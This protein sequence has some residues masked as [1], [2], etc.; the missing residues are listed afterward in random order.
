MIQPPGRSSSAI[1]ASVRAGSRWCIRNSRVY[2]RSN[3]SC[4]SRSWTS[5]TRT[6]TLSS[7]SVAATDR[8]RC[9]AASLKSIP[10]TCPSGPTS[11]AI[12]A[13]APR[14]PQPQSS[15]RHPGSMPTL[16]NAARAGSALSSAIFSSRRRSSSLLSR[17]YRLIRSPIVSCTGQSYHPLQ[18]M[19]TS[20]AARGGRWR[21]GE[22]HRDAEPAGSPGGE[23]ERPIVGLGDALD[24]GQAE[25]DAGVACVDAIA[26]ALKRLGERGDP[27]WRELLA[28]VLDGEC[29]A[30]AVS[31]GRDPHGAL[32]GQVVDDRVVHE[33]RGEL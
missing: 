26:A 19:A 3:P 5:P 29:H 13:S 20:D 17:R 25:A 22:L 31:A 2:A 6:S 9:T 21:G 1:A 28:G 30:F 32:A 18:A 10:T 24:D 23:G 7:P 33:V 11:S 27:L 15:T 12:T 4:P 8:A 14:G 16:R